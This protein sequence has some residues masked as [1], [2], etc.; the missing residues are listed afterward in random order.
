[1]LERRA[2]F[3]AGFEWVRTRPVFEPR[4]H[5]LIT[6]V[7]SSLRR[8]GLLVEC[9]GSGALTVDVAYG[10]KAIDRSLFHGRMEARAS[11]GGL[12]AVVPP[13]AGWARLTGYDTIPIDSRDP[14]A[15]GFQV[16]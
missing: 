10:D 3:I 14:F 2:Q 16:A 15:H 13:I 8:S 5:D 4:G 6:N 11:V 12:D 1:M 7:P 9:P